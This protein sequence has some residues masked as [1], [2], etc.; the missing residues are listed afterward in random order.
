MA[1][2]RVRE[3]TSEFRTVAWRTCNLPV[4]LDDLTV[5]RYKR[6]GGRSIIHSAP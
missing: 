6:F 4:H 3:M 1:G 5:F 2:R